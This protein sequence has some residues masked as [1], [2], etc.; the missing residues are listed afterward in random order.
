MK[1]P[2]NIVGCARC[3]QNHPVE[4]KPFTNPLCDSDGTIWT[5][6]ALCP[7]NGEPILIIERSFDPPST[8]QRADGKD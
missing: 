1:S 6:W 7:V 4:V 8:G 2:L 5:H 3:K